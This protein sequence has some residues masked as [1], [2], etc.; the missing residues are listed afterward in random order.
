MLKSKKIKLIDVNDWDK[1]ITKTYKKPYNFQQQDGC[2][3]RGTFHFNVPVDLS[4]DVS[5]IHNDIPYEINGEIMCV[6]LETWLKREPKNDDVM[7]WERNF[8]PSVYSLIDDLY[9][10]GL[11]EKGSY[12]IEI[13]W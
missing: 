11:L 5:T 3:D 8:Y 9:K 4:Y 10:K 1:F 6:E 7:F 2:K 12:A 13:D